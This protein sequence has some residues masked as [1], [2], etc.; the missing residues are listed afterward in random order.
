MAE[1]GSGVLPLMRSLNQSESN[2]SRS[3]STAKRHT[4][5]RRPAC[6]C[7]PSPCQMRIFMDQVW[8]EPSGQA[9]HPGWNCGDDHLAPLMAVQ[10]CVAFL[11]GLFTLASNR[12]WSIVMFLANVP[13]W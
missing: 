7:V 5:R 2:R 9:F 4:H 1:L 8:G 6:L 10:V 12:D 3:R 11:R 13:G